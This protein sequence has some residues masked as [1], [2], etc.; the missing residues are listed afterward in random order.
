MHRFAQNLHIF[1]S[2]LGGPSFLDCVILA[3]LFHWNRSD[4]MM[5][6]VL[7]ATETTNEV[8]LEHNTH[9]ASERV[10]ERTHPQ[11]GV[12]HAKVRRRN[13]EEKSP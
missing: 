7:E 3:I 5:M 12:E 1:W 13:S 6:I 11:K 10:S 2:K 8:E 9:R 4:E